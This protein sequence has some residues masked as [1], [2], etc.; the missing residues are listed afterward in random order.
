MTRQP[1]Y[2]IS[3]EVIFMS[4]QVM[5]IG[6]VVIAI[7]AGFLIFSNKP[8]SA[9]EEMMERANEEPMMEED[10]SIMEGE[11]GMMNIEHEFTVTGSNFKFD[12]DTMT[13]KKGNTVKVT[14]MSEDSTHDFV[15][16]EFGVKTKV[17]KSGEKEVITFVADKAGTYSFYC[18]VG[19]H[20]A[21]GMEGTLIVE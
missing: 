13:V 18:S 19:N 7:L 5:I 6:G 9:P 16:D 12:T 1:I 10:S 17:L 2:D 11:E 8:V 20:R 14:F 21:M 3:L 4:K 15:I